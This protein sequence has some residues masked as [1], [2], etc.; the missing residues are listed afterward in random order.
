MSVHYF[1]DSL[2]G[3]ALDLSAH[4]LVQ[5]F[6]FPH[7]CECVA[8]IVRGVLLGVASIVLVRQDSHIHQ[9]RRPVTIGILG[10]APIESEVHPV[11]L[12]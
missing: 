10:M 9:E 12:G 3:V 5:M 8:S 4:R 2:A 11:S 7:G 6:L 1:A